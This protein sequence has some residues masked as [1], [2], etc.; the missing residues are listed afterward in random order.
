MKQKTPPEQQRRLGNKKKEQ[1]LGFP[2]GQEDTLRV[3][4]NQ[5]ARRDT[6]APLT[7]RHMVSSSYVI[8]ATHIQRPSS[9]LGG[10]PGR[11]TLHTHGTRSEGSELPKEASP[12]RS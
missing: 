10:G 12:G 2:A 11:V 7:A 9:A 5:T 8:K 3:T 4:V 1:E 6:E